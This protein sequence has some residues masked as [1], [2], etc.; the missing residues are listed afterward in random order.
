MQDSS[1]D[2]PNLYKVTIGTAVADIVHQLSVLDHVIESYNTELER[3]QPLYSGRV[4]V[5]FIKGDRVKIDGDAFY[6]RMP[7]IGKMIKT[8]NGWRF[9]WV[10]NPDL[11]NLHEYRVGKGKKGDA[12]V[13]QLLKRLSEMLI[14]R[15]EIVFELKKLRPRLSKT[16]Q[17]IE[18]FHEKKMNQLIDLKPRIL[19]DWTK[20]A[21]ALYKANKSDAGQ[22][23]GDG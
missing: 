7:A 20:D 15:S 9:M 12:V 6:E 19:V 23:D 8:R 22:Q 2:L 14:R 13:V 1:N 5:K 18:F 21:D 3:A 11:E 17:S 10:K 16:A 4:L